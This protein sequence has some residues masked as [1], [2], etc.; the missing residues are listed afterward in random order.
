MKTLISELTLTA[1]LFGA[2]FFLL[3]LAADANQE[4]HGEYYLVDGRR[5]AIDIS[6]CTHGATIQDNEIVCR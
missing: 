3:S 2:A 1:L 5:V 6:Q 4:K